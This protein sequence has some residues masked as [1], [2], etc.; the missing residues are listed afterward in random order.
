M[1]ID[2]I[3]YIAYVVPLTLDGKSLREIHS[4]VKERR[5]GLVSHPCLFSRTQPSLFEAM[6]PLRSLIEVATLEMVKRSFL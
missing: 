4:K 5:L 3:T 2:K 6:C 1:E